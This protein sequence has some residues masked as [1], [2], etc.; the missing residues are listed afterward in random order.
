MVVVV[1]EA[2]MVVVMV[3]GLVVAPVM[4]VLA[5]LEVAPV[6]VVAILQ[7]DAVVLVALDEV[8]TEVANSLCH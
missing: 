7:L 4:V 2:T 6:M 3:V 1:V 8:G 5:G